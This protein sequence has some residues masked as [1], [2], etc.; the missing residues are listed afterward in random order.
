MKYELYILDA[1]LMI[2]L[3]SPLIM[4]LYNKDINK[5]IYESEQTQIRKLFENKPLAYNIF[6]TN[7][8]KSLSQDIKDRIIEETLKRNKLY[9][10]HILSK[11]AFLNEEIDLNGCFKWHITK[12]GHDYWKELH[13]NVFKREFKK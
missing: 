2:F 1:F 13:I 7:E 3:L 8:F 5:K 9:G 4:W 12:E 10:R 11:E 6:Q